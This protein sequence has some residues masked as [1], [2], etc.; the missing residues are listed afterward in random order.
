MCMCSCVCVL[1]RLHSCVVSL[2]RALPPF[3]RGCTR[4]EGLGLGWA[5]PHTGSHHGSHVVKPWVGNG[6]RPQS[7]G[8]NRSSRGAGDAASAS[9]AAGGG[10]GGAAW[11]K[12][13]TFISPYGLS[14]RAAHFPP[15]RSHAPQHD[16]SPLPSPPPHDE[17]PVDPSK[18]GARTFGLVLFGAG[19]ET[20]W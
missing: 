3:G 18:T 1:R 2:A 9:G 16:A 7:R 8:R 10:V 4:E 14:A 6:S 13:A 15:A 12:C 11:P 5:R 20:P 17:G 19:P